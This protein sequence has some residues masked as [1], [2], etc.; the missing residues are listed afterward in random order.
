MTTQ[1]DTTDLRALTDRY[2][3]AWERRDADAIA[4][5]HTEDSVFHLHAG[6]EPARG[7]EAVR[8]AFAAMFEQWPDLSFEQVSLHLGEDCW[9]VEWRI[10]SGEMETD[11]AD[12]VTIEDGLV[13]SKQSYIDAVAIQAQM[14]QAAAAT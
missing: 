10:R 6:Q 7:R 14:E 2:F 12:I 9:A 13:K 5:L 11:L 4:A 8:D 3:D 1:T